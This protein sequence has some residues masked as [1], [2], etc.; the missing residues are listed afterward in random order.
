MKTF[1][2]HVKE[3]HKQGK[4]G[5][6]NVGTP[7]VNSV[8]DGSIG[9]HNIHDPKVL[10]RVNGFVTQLANQEY[11]NPKARVRTTC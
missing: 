8:E 9:V 1:K 11:L 3:G 4:Y 6:K 2:Q 5:L 10:E 7:E